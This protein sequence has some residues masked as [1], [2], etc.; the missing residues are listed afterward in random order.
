[1]PLLRLPH[2]IPMGLP[3]KKDDLW[4]P[5]NLA[6]VMNFVYIYITKKKSWSGSDL[7]S[8]ACGRPQTS[9]VRYVC[10][11]TTILFPLPL[12]LPLPLP[13]RLLDLLRSSGRKR[14]KTT[15][16]GWSRGWA[17]VKSDRQWPYPPE[18]T[19]QRRID[20]TH[21][22]QTISSLPP[23]PKRRPPPPEISSPPQ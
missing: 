10:S 3:P 9:F 22:A 18:G 17:G 1:M 21:T 8:E 13:H 19:E 15:A 16:R 7:S 23:A 5:N 4:W 6:N 2:P 12:P 20:S 14:K 11:R